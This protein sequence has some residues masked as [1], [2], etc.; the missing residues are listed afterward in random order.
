MRRIALCALM[1]KKPS[2]EQMLSRKSYASRKFYIISTG[3]HSTKGI[4]QSERWDT[5]QQVPLSAVDHRKPYMPLTYG[6][7]LPEFTFKA[8]I[9]GILL[10]DRGSGDRGSDVFG[11]DAVIMDLLDWYGQWR[12]RWPR[13]RGYISRH[14]PQFA[15]S[16]QAADRTQ[17]ARRPYLPPRGLQTW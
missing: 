2:N 17:S 8:A 7:D 9:P 6:Q 13:S 4:T 11:T 14:R 1:M 3:V 5:G 10:R 16:A 12:D 15:T